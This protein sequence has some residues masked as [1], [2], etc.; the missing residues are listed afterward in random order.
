[1]KRGLRDT[2]LRLDQ[3]SHGARELSS[4]CLP[5]NAAVLHV[6]RQQ[7]GPCRSVEPCPQGC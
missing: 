3:V 6:W 4:R 7:Q 1:V 2:F 5:S